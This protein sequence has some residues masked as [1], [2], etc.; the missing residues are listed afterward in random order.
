[1]LEVVQSLTRAQPPGW[2]GYSRRID[3]RM[4]LRWPGHLSSAR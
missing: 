1:M 2:T 3:S 4:L